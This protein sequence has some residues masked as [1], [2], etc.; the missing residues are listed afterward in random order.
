M[1]AKERGFKNIYD[2]FVRL[3]AIAKIN[4]M[5]VNFKFLV[6]ICV[7]APLAMFSQYSIKGSAKDTTDQALNGAMVRILNSYVAVATNADGNYKISDLSDGTYQVVVEYIGYASQQKEVVINGADVE[8]NFNLRSSATSLEAIIVEATRVKSN[9]PI[10][11]TNVSKE[12]LA[13]NNLGQD[14]AF[15]LQT[16]PSIVSTSDAGAGVGYTGFRIRGSDATRINVTV[17]GIP[18]NDAESHGVY[19]V[20]M[21]DFAS[22]TEN[23]QIQRGVGTSTNGSAAFGASVNLKTDLVSE[24]AYG[25]ISSSYGSFNTN[26]NTLKLGTGLL[27]KHWAIDGRLS[28][29]TSDGYIDRA[30]SDLSS[31]YLSGGYYGKKTII[32]AITFAGKEKTYQSWYG[33]PEAKLNEDA[34]GIQASIDNNWFGTKDANNLINSGRTYNYYTYDNEVDNY[35]QDHYQLHLNHQFNSNLSASAAGHYTYGRGYYEQ[36]RVQDDLVDY[37]LDSVI[38]NSDTVTTSDLIRRRWL[39]N[40]FFGGVFNVKYQ[41]NKLNLVV[42]GGLNKYIG[43]HFGEIIWAQYASNSSIRDKYYDNTGTKTDGN[44]Y[45]KAD[46]AINDKLD[47]FVDVQVRNVTYKAE[48]I[49]SDQR[50]LGVDTAFT[51]VNPKAGVSYAIN[52]KLRSYVS[53]SV[54]NR[55]PVRNDFIDNPNNAQPSHETMVDY[56][57]GVEYKSSRLYTQA[58]LYYMD[59]TNQLVL[60]GALNDV[61][62]SIRTNVENSYRA[63]IEIVA[64]YKFHKNFE[65]MVNGT[66]SQNKI[67]EFTEVI[68][69]Y[70]NG[71]DLV[72]NV[73]KDTDISFSPSVIAASV[74][75]FRPAKGLELRLQTKYVGS[76]FLDNTASKD[77][78][79]DAYTTTDFGASYSLKLKNFKEIQFNVLVNNVFDEMYSSNGYTWGFISG[80]RITENWLYPQAG[81]NF[82]GGVTLK[83]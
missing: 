72:E 45:A 53:V 51:F 39:D 76:Q 75:T 7:L 6:A 66:F 64:G 12:D 41:T 59:Y 57:G 79:L 44:V 56:E 17:N 54:G 62:S 60:T 13:K 16:T 14:I 1:L 15:L 52:E 37:N 73:Y 8:L 70:T 40:H 46:Y 4:V 2:A 32:K 34:A 27:N 23:I 21:P 5:K 35:A 9:S 25:E 31:Y 82:L 58:N 80:D 48:G 81:I 43:D 68:A 18:M 22:S 67:E 47:V 29:I 11:H 24:D 83:F 42:G 69:D 19:W 28:S 26:K 78:Q 65:W 49:D 3:R 61:G 77:R 38:L 63:G 74:F 33:T 20:N 71:F 10:A 36:F 55:E 50:T 30:S